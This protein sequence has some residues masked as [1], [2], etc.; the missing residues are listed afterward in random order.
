MNNS[1]HIIVVV[2]TLSVALSCSKSGNDPEAAESIRFAGPVQTK[3]FTDP[4]GTSSVFYVRDI[5]N[6]TTTHIDNL[7][8]YN[9]ED[10]DWGYG[11]GDKDQYKWRNGLHHFF[12]WL[13]TDG[14]VQTASFFGSDPTLAGTTLSFPAKNMTNATAQYDFLYSQV[15]QRNTSSN[16]YSEVPLI[17]KHLFAQVAITFVADPDLPELENPTVYEVYL[18]ESFRNKKAAS[19]SFASPGDPEVT[20][21]IPREF[22]S[23]FATKNSTMASSGIVYSPTTTPFDVLSQTQS[24]I[25]AF[26]YIWPMTEEELSETDVITVKYK[27]GSG[28]TRTVDM[29]FPPGTSWQAGHK[30]S[31][32]I[33]YMGGILIVNQEVLPWDYSSATGLQA[34]SQSAMASWAGWDSATCTESRQTVTFRSSDIPVHGIFRINSPTSCT[35][36]VTLSNT[37]K[38]SIEGGS[39]TIGSGSGQINPG[40]NI[41]FYISAK[42]GAAVGDQ[43]GLTFTV[44]TAGRTI[45]IDSEVQ[46]DGL[47]T[48]TL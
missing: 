13:K 21:T 23:L 14:I 2:L 12:G 18:N 34:D 6:E 7:L 15:I 44:T 19:I 42:P 43:T 37:E 39:G 48:I 29:S 25:S 20:Y 17:F 1:F 3:V 10:M 24:H 41:E 4:A 40:Q 30:Y 32:T 38:F 47:F 33:S 26:Y 28:V 27:P 5:F 46:K 35:Y 45:N 31:Y 16:D 9:D 22:E 36:N 8:K 11:S